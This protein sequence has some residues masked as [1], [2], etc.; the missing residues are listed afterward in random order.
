MYLYTYKTLLLLYRY[1]RDRSGT[2]TVAELR[3]ALAELGADVTQKKVG[4]GVESV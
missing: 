4:V 1:D 3:R 2:L